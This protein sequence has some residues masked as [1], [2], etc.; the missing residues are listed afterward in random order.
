MAKQNYSIPS[1]FG[2][3]HSNRDF[4]HKDS[5]GKNQFN[6][7]FPISLACYLYHKNTDNVYIILDDTKRIKHKK[8]SSQEIFGLS[9]LSDD[10]FFSFESLYTPY[11]QYV[12]DKL[13]RIDLVTQ[14]RKSGNCIKC[15]EIKLTAIPD[16]STWEKTSEE[17]GAEIVVRPD[18]IVYLACSIA[19]LYGKDNQKLRTFFITRFKEP[20]NW[21][22]PSEVLPLLPD[23]IQVIDNIVLKNI[24]FQEP[25]IMQPVWKTEGKHPKLSNN[26]LDIFIWSNFSFIE[27]FISEYRST[28]SF[29]RITRQ[30]RT[31]IWLF[32]MLYDFSLNGQF[33]YNHIFDELSYNT[34]NDKAFAI[35][36]NKT[37]IYMKSDELTKP[38][39]TKDEIKN[40]V[41]GG[42]HNLLSPERRFDAILF[43]NPELFD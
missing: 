5:W 43:N 22:N 23:M 15:I 18:T 19:K 35:N 9:P 25:L 41:L 33:N 26:C 42:G 3:K 11:Q 8:I 28:C 36:G 17:Y 27:L 37:H 21:Y 4:T 34:L 31:I 14:S 10:L 20:R 6:N 7:S 39:I 30:I 13:P 12:I 16:I 40:I 32:K 2:I 24:K 29:D 38:R 1:L